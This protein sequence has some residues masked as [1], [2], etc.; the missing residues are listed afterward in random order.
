MERYW[1]VSYLYDGG[2]GN[3]F[4]NALSDGIGINVFQIRDNLEKENISKVTIINFIEISK[5]QFLRD[6][7]YL[8][9]KKEEQ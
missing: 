7:N 2:N 4:C 1:F 3:G 9:S 8:D 5:E 6:L